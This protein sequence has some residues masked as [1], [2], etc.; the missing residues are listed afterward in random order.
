MESFIYN[1]NNQ[2]QAQHMMVTPASGKNIN[3]KGEKTMF[4]G[5]VMNSVIITVINPLTR[6]SE[7]P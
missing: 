2:S 6:G 5:T 3:K 7:E 1:E 4:E